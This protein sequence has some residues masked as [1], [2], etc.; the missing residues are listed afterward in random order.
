[1]N[2][3]DYDIVWDGSCRG[4]ITDHFLRRRGLDPTPAA[5]DLAFE[6]HLRDNRRTCPGPSIEATPVLGLLEASGR[7]QTVREIAYA[8]RVESGQ[9]WGA[10]YRLMQA[11][12]VERVDAPAGATRVSTHWR[13]P[14]YAYRVTP[15]QS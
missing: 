14:S 4:S 6:E 3:D 12:L 2:T 15:H 10:I 9:V 11:G 1:M 5:A 13:G 7:P 8:F